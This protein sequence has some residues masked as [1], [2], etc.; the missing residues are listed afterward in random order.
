MEVWHLLL[1][2]SPYL[3]FGFGIA[4]ILKILIPDKFLLKHLSGKKWS[5]VFKAAMIG[6]PLP[7]CSCGVIPVAAHLKK[8]GAG[9]GAVISFLTS[10]PTSGI[11]S[12]L[13]TYSLLGPIFAF[14]R[15]IASF[16]IGILAGL[17][18]NIFVADEVK[19]DKPKE[20]D[21]LKKG[22]CCI[23]AGEISLKSSVTSKIKKMFNYAY[24]ELIDDVGG[25]LIIGIFAGA[26]ISYFVPASI[27]ENYFS[28]P[29]VSYPVMLLMGVPMYVCATGSIPI[30]ASLI[31]KGMSPGAGLVF[32]IAGPATNAATLSLIGGKLGIKTLFVYLSS[33]AIG[34]IGF[35]LLTD[36]FWPGLGN[37]I[38][39][40][41]NSMQML[42]NW[43][44]IACSIIL[45]L[46]LI[47]SFLKRITVKEKKCEHC[48]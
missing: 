3:L 39:S 22:T 15:I 42:P 27:I 44:E 21:N 26:L 13:A 4:G 8:S 34:A 29:F 7:L 30:A 24:V 14:I 12:I 1:A 5:S 9:K 2:M 23:S 16:F 18:S 45:L 31:L 20:K 43:L 10:T 28:N 46:F 32:L 37:G 19:A 17:L 35:A 47:R 40:A 25:W 33:I 36:H 6:V 48:K 38:R 11:D 41:S